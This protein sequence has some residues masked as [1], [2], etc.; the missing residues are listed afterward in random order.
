MHFA[1]PILSPDPRSF[2]RGRIWSTCAP[3]GP[4]PISLSDEAR[5]FATTF[6]GGFLFVSLLL[7]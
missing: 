2:G 6:A 4:P 5:L 3:P 1:R 7:A